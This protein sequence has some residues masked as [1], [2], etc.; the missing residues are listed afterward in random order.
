MVAAA[1]GARTTDM[2]GRARAHARADARARAAV[3]V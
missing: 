2:A 1:D 3:G